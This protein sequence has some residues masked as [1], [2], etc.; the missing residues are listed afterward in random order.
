MVTKETFEAQASLPKGRS[1]AVALSAMWLSRVLTMSLSLLLMPILFRNFESQSLGTWLLLGQVGAIVSFLDFGIT[2]VLTRRVAFAGV[3]QPGDGDSSRLTRLAELLAAARVLYRVAATV[4]FVVPV[5]AGWFL[6]ADIGLDD[7]LLQQARVAWTILCAGYAVALSGGLWSASIWGLGHMTAA[8]VVSTICGIA[9]LASQVAAVLL[10][11][12]MATLAVIVLVSSLVQR[13]LTL[14]VLRKREPSLA[15]IR[16]KARWSIIV[17]L[18]APSLKYWFTEIGAVMLLRTDQLFIAGFH[19][20][21]RIPTYYAA[22]SLVYNM[23]MVAMAVGEV[24]FVHVSRLWRQGAIATAKALVVRN[25]RIALALMLSGAATMAVIGDAVIAVWLGSGHFVGYPILLTFCGM[26]VL[27]VQQSLMFGFSRAT[28]YEAFAT[29]YLVAGL[30]NIA[31]TWILADWFGLP[32]IALATL[33]A[34]LVTTNWFV[35]RTALRRLQI[36]WTDYVRDVALPAAGVASL[37]YLAAWCATH[38]FTLLSPL[39]RVAVGGT[40]ACMAMSAGFWV[41]V[42]G[43][44]TRLHICTE[45]HRFVGGTRTSTR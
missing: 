41:L 40:A 22:Y 37:A 3:A 17:E 34:Q 39:Q 24:S 28:E 1:V 2:N 6:L 16:A 5:C 36:P 12:R 7:A 33:V 27:F 42:F 11:G 9:A 25:T 35:P 15:V 44:T 32:G 29:C 14:R 19:E 23:A 20:T 31:L 43:A 21:A 13:W 45:L 30:L 8:S 38:A 4:G 10:G 18:V 26:L